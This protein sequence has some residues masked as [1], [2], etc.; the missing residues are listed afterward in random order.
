MY[1]KKNKKNNIKF[2]KNHNLNTLLM[3]LPHDKIFC[4]HFPPLLLIRVIKNSL[5]KT[6]NLLSSV[7]QIIISINMQ[8]F[9]RSLD[10]HILIFKFPFPVV[11]ILLIS[12]IPF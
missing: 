3:S 9:D 1:I 4:Y 7:D 11:I 6:T 2:S 5:I 10:Y 8:S 12:P